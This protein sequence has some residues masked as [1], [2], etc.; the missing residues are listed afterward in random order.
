MSPGALRSCP[1][2]FLARAI[3][4]VGLGIACLLM[5]WA[6]EAAASLWVKHFPGHEE[7]DGQGPS[8]SQ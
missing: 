2:C 8:P 3:R 5:A 7:G 1:S 4:A 6:L